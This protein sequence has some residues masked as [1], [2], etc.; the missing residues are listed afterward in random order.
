MTC[1]SKA[2]S[3]NPSVLIDDRGRLFSL[4]KIT[5]VGCQIAGMLHDP[6][7]SRRNAGGHLASVR[8]GE[9]EEL[10]EEL[11]RARWVVKSSSS[12]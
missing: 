12:V 7:P 6:N 10:M 3:R 9:E 1:W 8:T 2:F 11:V 5:H 4:L